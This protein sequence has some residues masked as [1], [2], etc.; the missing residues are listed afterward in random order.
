MGLSNPPAHEGAPPA[1]I[2]VGRCGQRDAAEGRA[3]LGKPAVNSVHLRSAAES[4]RTLRPHGLWPAGLLCPWDFPGKSP[5]VGCHFL[6]QGIFPTQGSNPHLLHWWVTSLP[7]SHRGSTALLGRHS[8][9]STEKPSGRGTETTTQ[10][11]RQTPHRSDSIV[12][13]PSG[14]PAS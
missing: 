14:Q 5:G 11:P 12:Q 2:G 9:N 4:C 3:G 1:L 13:Q 7:L 10:Q 8:L 6:L